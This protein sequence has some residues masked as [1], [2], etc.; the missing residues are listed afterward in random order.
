M[1][2]WGLNSTIDQLYNLTGS[3]TMTA[4]QCIEHQITRQ[5]VQ[6]RGQVTVKQDAARTAINVWT[7]R[8]IAVLAVTAGLL[9]LGSYLEQLLWAVVA[10]TTVLTLR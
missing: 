10:A 8:L 1:A 5:I 6:R 4:T 2:P 7:E 3:N 9:I